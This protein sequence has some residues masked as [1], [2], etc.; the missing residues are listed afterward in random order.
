[1]EIRDWLV[2]HMGICQPCR[3][4]HPADLPS[5]PFLLTLLAALPTCNLYVHAHVHLHLNQYLHL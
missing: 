4:G 1:M 3:P 5:F 2:A